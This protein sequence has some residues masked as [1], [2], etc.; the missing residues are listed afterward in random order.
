MIF[1]EILN[2]N[3]HFLSSAF[4]ALYLLHCWRQGLGVHRNVVQHQAIHQYD[5]FQILSKASLQVLSKAQLARCITLTVSA[6]A[7]TP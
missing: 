1:I 2:K 6:R 7:M 5:F 4:G 3:A